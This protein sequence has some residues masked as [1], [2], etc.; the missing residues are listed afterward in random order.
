MLEVELHT[1]PFASPVGAIERA[2]LE[3]PLHH[4]ISCHGRGSGRAVRAAGP[5][6][7]GCSRLR[8]R[9]DPRRC[10]PPTPRAHSSSLLASSAL[11]LQVLR[12]FLKDFDD[13]ME[14]QDEP[15][16]A[17][18]LNGLPDEALS[19]QTPR[20]AFGEP[21][22]TEVEPKSVYDKPAVGRPGS[23]RMQ[24]ARRVS[25]GPSKGGTPAAAARRA[26]PARPASSSSAAARSPPARSR[27]ASASSAVRFE[28]RAAIDEYGLPDYA[29]DAGDIGSTFDAVHWSALRPSSAPSRRSA[30]SSSFIRQV[31][32][33][34][35]IS[36]QAQAT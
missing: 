27:L 23:A 29:D 13:K 22:A 12:A 7:A 16:N 3:R 11:R 4:T 10:E 24:G 20:Q 5:P 18:T 19:E 14:M 28:P 36:S 35:Q 34:S 33:V 26:A 30:S 9:G 15:K 21:W 17:D 6:A 8:Q 2:P 31:S 25:T 32:R 1:V